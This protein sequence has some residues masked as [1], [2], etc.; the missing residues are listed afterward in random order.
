[1]QNR[2]TD[3]LN[4]WSIFLVAHRRLTSQFDAELREGAG[5]S[6]DEYD[7]LYQ[8]RRSGRAMAMSELAEQVL[9]SRASTTRVVDRLVERG[10][11][12]R[13]HDDRD[14]RRVF[15]ELTLEGRERQRVAGRLHL[16]GIDRLVG[17]PLK[18]LDVKALAA[19]LSALAVSAEPRPSG[20]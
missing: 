12:H 2:E 18:G 10:W 17:G 7:V 9:V 13:W 15:V 1:M 6:L 4:L 14:R 5:M 3:I 16:K 8:L 19:G 11:A 20:L